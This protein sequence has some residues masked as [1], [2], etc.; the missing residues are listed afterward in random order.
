MGLVLPLGFAVVIATTL[1][2][3]MLIR[4]IL[5]KDDSKLKRPRGTARRHLVI[6]V[7]FA[8]GWVFGLVRTVPGLSTNAYV[9]LEVL[10]IVTGS[11]LGF[12]FFIIHCLLVYEVRVAFKKVF[13]RM[14]CQ[15][16]EEQEPEDDDDDAPRKSTVTPDSLVIG[17]PPSG[18]K[19]KEDI[20]MNDY[21]Y[22]VPIK[23]QDRGVEFSNNSRRGRHHHS[24]KEIQ[25]V[26]VNLGRL[27]SDLSSPA[28]SEDTDLP[29]AKFPSVAFVSTEKLDSSAI[30][31]PDP[32]EET[33][34]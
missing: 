28:R 32:D 7:I 31:Q 29:V 22:S 17:R 3:L 33:E 26:K 14:T 2:I 10:F 21:I 19:G 23:K 34:L 11:L 30:D 1:S 24:L 12:Y 6:F 15:D 4:W 25:E 5:T 8:I 20:E 13:Y 16:Y 9:V 18:M 27:D